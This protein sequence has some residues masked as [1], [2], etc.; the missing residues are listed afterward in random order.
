MFVINTPLMLTYS[1]TNAKQRICYH[2]F[3]TI[4]E[5]C[6]TYVPDGVQKPFL[7]RVHVKLALCC[8]DHEGCAEHLPH[9]NNETETTADT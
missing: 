9:H 7:R 4:A 5:F 3:V 8:R 6:L 1:D 2:L